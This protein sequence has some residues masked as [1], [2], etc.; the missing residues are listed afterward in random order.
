M[1]VNHFIYDLNFLVGLHKQHQ[2]GDILL[3][4]IF[5]KFQKCF[6]K[7]RIFKKLFY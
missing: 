7:C 4:L 1:V 5:V 6:D 2:K 3:G